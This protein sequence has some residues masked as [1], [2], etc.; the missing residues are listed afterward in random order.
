MRI[1]IIRAWVI[2]I[3]MSPAAATE[4]TREE[5]MVVRTEPQI[6][7]AFGVDQQE[8]CAVLEMHEY[9]VPSEIRNRKYPTVIVH[10][11]C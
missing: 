7:R 2:E 4:L 1:I 8:D 9:A 11:A 5:S 3:K 10:V 6:S